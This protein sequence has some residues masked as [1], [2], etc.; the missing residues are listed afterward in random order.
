MQEG[1]ILAK[2]TVVTRNKGVKMLKWNFKKM[3]KARGIDKPARW[4][5]NHGISR[6][7][8]SRIAQNKCDRV[9]M[10]D[11]YIICRALNCTPDDVL[12]Y[13]PVKDDATDTTIALNVLKPGKSEEDAAALLR[14]LSFKELKELAKKLRKDRGEEE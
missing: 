8:A 5:V 14:T 9:A 3:F 7:V 13:Y 6:G 4:M 11:L 2:T 12:E 1:N 10:K